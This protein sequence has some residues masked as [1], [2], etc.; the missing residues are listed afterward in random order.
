MSQI[1]TEPL[2]HELPTAIDA[3]VRTALEELIRE[4]TAFGWSGQREREIVSL[5]CFGPLLSQVRA[6]AVLH[7]PRQIGIEV[8]VPQVSSQRQLSGRS[9]S[10]QQV[11]KDIVLWSAP[12]QTCWDSFCAP[13]VRPIAVLEWKHNVSRASAY[14]LGWLQAFSAD[15]PTFAGYAVTSGGTGRHFHLNCSRVHLG[16]VDSE[17]LTLG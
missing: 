8:A 12:R 5:F 14:D 9:G 1:N 11:T 16:A 7:D 6:G 15:A 13:T 17:W 3:I 2:A 4:M 10:K